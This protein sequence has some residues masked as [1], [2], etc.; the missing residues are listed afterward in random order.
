MLSLCGSPLKRAPPVASD[1]WFDFHAGADSFAQPDSPRRTITRSIFP[2]PPDRIFTIVISLGTAT[3]AG[4]PTL[5]AAANP[6][7][8][9]AA[10]RLAFLIARSNS[11]VPANAFRVGIQAQFAE[12]TGLFRWP[13]KKLSI[14]RSAFAASSPLNPWP[15]PSRVRSRASTAAA[16][17]RSV[18]H[19]ACS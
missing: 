3:R 10:L 14:S 11:E 15:A 1:S 16:F 8:A 18:I 9:E 19:T 4:N 5:A 13:S 12:G 6:A 7:A 17:S 2:D